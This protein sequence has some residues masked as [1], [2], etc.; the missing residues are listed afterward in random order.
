MA[1]KSVYLRTQDP[2]GQPY[3]FLMGKRSSLTADD[4][5]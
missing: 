4:L 2:E 3:R 1:S 5:A